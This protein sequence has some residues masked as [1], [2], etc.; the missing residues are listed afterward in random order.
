MSAPEG[1]EIVMNDKTRRVI[2]TAL[3]VLLALALAAPVLVQTTGLTVEQAP[4]LATV[5]AGAAAVARAMQSDFVEA[6]LEQWGL[7]TP[8]PEV[9]PAD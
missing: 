7:A 3:Q 2:R 4:W 9:P 5:L 1:R 6:L 8:R